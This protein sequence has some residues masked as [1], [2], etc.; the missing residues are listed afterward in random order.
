M[1]AISVGLSALKS[2]RVLVGTRVYRRGNS[3]WNVARL[4]DLFFTIDQRRSG[5]CLKLFPT[6][7]VI[8]Y[9]IVF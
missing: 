1:L 5:F 8:V 4:F 9:I 3:V 6:L 7:P 2:R